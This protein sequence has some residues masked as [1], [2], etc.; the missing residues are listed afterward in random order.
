M[1]SPLVFGLAIWIGFPSTGA[2][3]DVVSAVTGSDAGTDRWNAVLQR[4]VA[5][6][7]HAA[8]LPFD[9]GDLTTGS[10]S[11][12]GLRADGIGDVAFKG[13]NAVLEATPD[14]DRI[15]RSQK[16]GRV[17]KVAPVAPPK[18]FN[19]GSVNQRM[20]SLL[21]PGFDTD[22]KMAFARTKARGE[23][24]QLA[25]TFFLRREKK[26]DP[27]LPAM[28]AKLV[29]NDTPDVLAT[30]YAPA[31]PDYARVS[32]FASLLK[33]DKPE[34]GRFVPP[35]DRKDHAWAAKPLPA[36]AFSQAEQHCL[37]TGI[38]FEARGEPVS[39]QAAVAQVIL[40][41]V[42]APSYPDTICGV[43]YQNDSWRNRCQFSF[44]CDG[45]K[46]RV[47]EPK[48][49]Q[50]AK[51]VALPVT[52]GKIWLPEVGSSTHYHANYVSP[53][54]APTMKRMQQIGRHIFYRTFNGGWS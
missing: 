36:A 3:Q 50:T 22:A 34:A 24:L 2:H 4:S 20:S 48:H 54:W 15:T 5:G 16:Q 37:A 13:K 49:W 9:N 47:T 51:D 26:A 10:I 8:Q 14:E 43:V 21:R 17:V 1:L 39:G 38:Y 30:A 6:S 12:A 33:N 35:I 25:S 45:I 41:R 53:R 18:A 19:A 28:L 7:T 32:P 44:A 42:R 31:K 27:A 11:G 29:T 46:D 23:E 40:N 52:A